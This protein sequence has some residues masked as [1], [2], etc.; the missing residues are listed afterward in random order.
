MSM[1]MDSR[2]AGARAAARS[3]MLTLLVALVPAEGS[4]QSA[5]GFSPDISADLGTATS[6][7]VDDEDVM[8]DNAAGSV[9]LALPPAVA[10]PIQVDVIAYDLL[11]G[12]ESLL[13]F[14]TAI[15]GLAGLPAGTTVEPRDVVSFDPVTS[16]YAFFFVGS[17]AGV[18]PG[19]QV[20][21]VSFDAALAPLLS[22][23]VSVTLPGVGPVDDED[24]VSFAGGLFAM[25]FDGSAN[26]IAVGLDLDGAHRVLGSDDLWVSFDASGVAGGVFFDDEDVLV[27]DL[28]ALTFAR[29]ADSSLSDP[30]D[31]PRA[32]LVALPEP[33]LP[34]SLLASASL[35]A[36]LHRASRRRRARHDHA[37]PLRISKEVET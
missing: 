6:T 25:L 29:Y 21:A 9:G 22:F 34:V 26:G 4:A 20:D 15:T 12:G 17:T 35:L 11:P 8:L 3:V 19:A 18:P 1:S 10:L 23:D 32:D 13:S 16:L 28:V 14:D 33:G 31:W 36:L 37:A 2:P 27:F 30:V 7:L 24:V 5:V